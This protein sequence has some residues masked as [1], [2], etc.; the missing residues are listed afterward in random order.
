MNVEFKEEEIQMANKHMKKC[1]NP[2]LTRKMKNKTRYDLKLIKLAKINFG[3]AQY[4]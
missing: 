3:N 4:W 2:L 1:L